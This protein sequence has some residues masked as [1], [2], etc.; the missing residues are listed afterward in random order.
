MTRGAIGDPT[1]WS[2]TTG[3]TATDIEA[4]LAREPPSVQERW[5]ARLYL[6]KALVFAVLGAFWL[7][8]GI[9]ALGPGFEA[10]MNLMREGGLGEI[11]G[12]AAVV[13]GAMADILIGLA[14]IYR[15][16]SRAGIYAALLISFGYAVLGT[17]LLPRLWTDPL[18]PMLKIGPIMVLLLVA[19][20]IR[21][22][23]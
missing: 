21:E 23:R 8:T 14:I 4:A 5:F 17:I 9:I 15:P 19:L 6:L 18:G 10:G 2:E 7:G 13:C 20:A 16:T 11:A 22:D 1:V 3:I 12:T